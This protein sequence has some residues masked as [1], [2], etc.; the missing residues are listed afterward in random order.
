[1]RAALNSFLWRRPGLLSIALLGLITGLAVM[2]A[3][4]SYRLSVHWFETNKFEEKVTALQLVDAFVADYTDIR[5][6]MLGDQAP[7]PATFR[8]HALTRFNRSREDDRVL[9]LDWLGVP[10]REIRTAPRD[11]ATAEA[12]LE[13]ARTGNAEPRSQWIGSEGQR[14][15]RT[16][17][18]SVA[19]QQACVDCHNLHLD[20]RTPWR[21]NDVMGAFVIDV[22]AEAFLL[23]ARNQAAL[24]GALL[25]AIA[26]AVAAFV[27]RLL[28]LRHIDAIDAAT[29]AERER[30]ALD[31]Q[32]TAEAANRAKSE[33]L[34]L[35]SHELRT[36]LNAIIGFSEIMAHELRGKIPLAYQDYARDIH[37]SGQHL[38]MV[39]GDIL[40]IA[41]AESSRFDLDEE[42]MLLEDLIEPC[43]RLMAPRASNGQVAL[44]AR[45]PAGVRLHCDVTKL[46][47]VV[48][49][50]LSNAVKFTRAGGRVEVTGYLTRGGALTIAITDTGIGIRPED[51]PRAF[52]PFEQV[53]STFQ[54]KHEGT[55]LGLPLAKALTELHGG[56]LTLD[57]VLGRGTQVSATLPAG[58]VVA[59]SI[60][61][62]AAS[63]EL[64]W[65]PSSGSLMRAQPV[66][67]AGPV[68]QRHAAIC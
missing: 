10:G 43:L 50:L 8:A 57:S 44:A 16:I 37:Q 63:P 5:G 31:S 22:P 7:V 62:S 4:A 66:T 46:R 38:M 20:G 61:E 56:S 15:F 68:D 23:D 60:L 26:T 54:R 29:S 35:M 2:L 11:A 14:T 13:A 36:P 25:F 17:A 19:T 34:A 48:L 12:I 49:N 3:V 18:P 40:D 33:F 27:F 21:L 52:K 64:R 55:G 24:L 53:E 39:I 65:D 59:L 6:R 42:E 45:I 28:H 30:A 1:M 9:H 67:G 51:V 32:R 47:Q 41:K 58:R